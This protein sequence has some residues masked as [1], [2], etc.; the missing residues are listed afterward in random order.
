MLNHTEYCRRLAAFGLFLLLCGISLS[1]QAETPTD[2]ASSKKTVS[3]KAVTPH[4]KAEL[5]ARESAVV[6]G[7][8]L[9]VALRFDII[10]HWHTY[11][12]NPGDSGLP[13]KIKWTL[14]EGFKA[15]AIEWAAPKKLPLGPL[16]NFGYENTV[17]HVVRIAT[18]NTLPANGSVSLKAAATWLVC[19]DVCI[20]EEAEFILT[21]PIASPATL[22]VKNANQALF[23]LANT[24][25]PKPNS[26]WK[27]TANITDKILRLQL[28]PATPQ[29][30]LP[31]EVSFYPDLEELILNAAPQ[32]L[33][34]A[35]GVLTLEIPLATPVNTDATTITGVVVTNA[36]L[37]DKSSAA[38]MTINAPLTRT[39][40]QATTAA[41]TPSAKVT[42]DTTT[43]TLLSALFSAFLGGL[44]LN[45]MPCVF[46]V[47]G[48][49]VM[50]FLQHAE[51]A[52][53]LMRAQ[54][55]A[56]LVGVLVSF[57]ILAGILVAVSA[58]G[59]ALGW[60]FQLQSPLFVL[61]LA[62]LFVLLALNLAG[63]FEIGASLQSAAGSVN[64]DAAPGEKRKILS[65]AF[66]SGVLATIVAT[67]CTAPFMGAALGF[68]IGA[69]AYV[70]FM[71]LTAV[72]IG[73]ALPVVMLSWFPQWLKALP[74]PG[75]WM[76]NLKQAMAFPLFATVAWLVW[77]LGSQLDNDAV[78]ATLM[79][80]VLLA[81]GAWCFGKLQARK[82][83]AALVTATVLAVAGGYIA[84][85]NT[86]DSK[87]GA[88]AKVTDWEPYSKAKIDA[89]I[90]SEKP[91]FIDFTATWCISCQVNKKVALTTS[92]V[93]AAFKK[94]GV[95]R[96]K[97]DWT[98]RDP[99]ITA[100]LASFGRNGVPLYVFYPK[101]ANGKPIILPEVLTPN[102][103]LDTLNGAK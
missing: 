67:P 34:T 31:T 103:V 4:L 58:T 72:A 70:V 59:S 15:G 60:G 20:P 23:D 92:E 6:A 101:G 3:S 18:P 21:L 79:G 74:R 98:K 25:I 45:L 27:A 33:S 55:W 96:I 26:N 35:N 22:T 93:E 47:L 40:A 51:A 28:S 48:I 95:L 12:K 91:I 73:M 37:G 46:P 99:E 10:A 75:A 54:G 8:P 13:T 41:T 2:A 50:G 16:T 9:T 83:F 49:K 81:L 85:P 82:P 69:P 102:I 38:M 44:I 39:G 17:M 78:L 65:A 52:P 61:F 89:Y 64:V 63:V 19:H 66:V 7:Q 76:E 29:A 68:T 84:W 42:T 11:W 100:A 88:S 57:W 62:A 94:Q 32:K 86:I 56:F 90:A 1:G 77:V 80:L 5:L 43:L 24:A 30:M 36:P 71:V 14:P 97:A 53:R 87:T